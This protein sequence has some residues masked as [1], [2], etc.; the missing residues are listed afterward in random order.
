M[1]V[2]DSEGHYIDYKNLDSGDAFKVDNDLYMKTDMIAS[3]NNGCDYA[4]NVRTGHV[5]W[6]KSDAE[7]KIAHAE[8]IVE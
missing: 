6:F 8:V 4:V 7:V 2:R 1:K 5:V 3:T